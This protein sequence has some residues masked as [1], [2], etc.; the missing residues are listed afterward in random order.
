MPL[1]LDHLRE[2]CETLAELL[3]VSNDRDLMKQLGEVV[4][5]GVRAGIVQYFELTRELAN[6]AIQEQLQLD[7]INLKYEIIPESKKINF[8]CLMCEAAK[9]GLIHD[10][11]AYIDYKRLRNKTTHSYNCELAEKAVAAMPEF[12]ESVRFLIEELT[13]RNPLR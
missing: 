3:E 8:A 12:L 4:E 7:E 10:A 11:D 5:K 13:R 6:Q 9:A 2:S 1:E